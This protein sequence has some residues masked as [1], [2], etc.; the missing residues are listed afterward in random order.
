[1]PSTEWGEPCRAFRMAFTSVFERVT[2]RRLGERYSA[3]DADRAPIKKTPASARI[4]QP[5]ADPVYR[6]LDHRADGLGLPGRQRGRAA[7][8]AHHVHLDVVQGIDV[9]IAQL[10]RPQEDGPAAGEAPLARDGQDRRL[11]PLE[12]RSDDTQYSA[13]DP[14]VPDEARVERRDPHVG[15]AHRQLRVVD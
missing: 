10:D 11:R 2:T 13:P 15:L 6:E 1:M 4:L 5:A 7:Q 14:R 12:L 3:L 9:G 8:P